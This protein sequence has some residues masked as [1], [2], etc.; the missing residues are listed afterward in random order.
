MGAELQQRLLAADAYA[1][2]LGI[3]WV[4]GSETECVV[5]MTLGPEHLNFADVAHGGVIFSLAD[6]AFSLASNAPG[7]LA[8]A[9]D[10][11]LVIP[12]A[13]QAGDVLTARA[14]EVSLGNKLAT[15]R[16]DVSGPDSQVVGLFTGTVYR[17]SRTH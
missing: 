16:V 11:H 17:T 14:T 4:S 12:A 7:R 3:S 2:A 13:S 10:T 15:Y 8:V 9:V 6:C 5:S 1:S